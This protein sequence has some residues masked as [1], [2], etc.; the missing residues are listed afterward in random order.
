[1]ETEINHFED[2][3]R[4]ARARPERQRLLFVFAGAELPSDASAEQRRRFEQ[5]EGG[6]LTPLMC[7][8]KLPDELD[9]FAALLRES[10]QFELPGQ[11][12]RLVFTAALAGSQGMTPSDGEVDRALNR[13]VEAVKSVQFASYLPFIREGLPVRLG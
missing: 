5:G 8:D 7:V 9:S 2:L 3:L 10:A 13:M 6:A 12:W 1:M 4:A 11:P